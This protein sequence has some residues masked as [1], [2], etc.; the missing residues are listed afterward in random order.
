ML[1]A[2]RK[3]VRVETAA[4]V[5]RAFIGFALITTLL[6]VVEAGKLTSNAAALQ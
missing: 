1:A 3:T 5:E 2:V 6:V 4:E